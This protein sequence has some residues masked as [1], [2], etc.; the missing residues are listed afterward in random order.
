MPI[1]RRGVVAKDLDRRAFGGGRQRV[2]SVEAQSSKV[3][4]QA[5]VTDLESLL[6]QA[7]GKI[8]GMFET[9][10]K[11]QTMAELVPVALERYEA[12]NRKGGGITGLSTGIPALDRATRG[13]KGGEMITIS[14]QTKDG[15][16]AFAVNIAAHNALAGIPVGIFSL[17]M[18]A[19]E[20]TDRLFSSDANVDLTRLS[21]GGFSHDEMDRISQAG[22]R[23]AGTRSY[24]Q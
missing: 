15:K 8:T 6:Q 4:Q 22:L 20:I 18:S 10:A 14:A 5:N 2:R 11:T 21:D 1:E 12:A 17:E 19:D 23:L 7:L 24:S 9:R 13:L 16:S 3:V